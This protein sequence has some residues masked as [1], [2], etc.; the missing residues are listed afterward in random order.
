MRQ[1]SGAL[2]TAPALP[3]VG[4]LFAGS[5]PNADGHTAWQSQFAWHS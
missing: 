1:P 4:R 3:V 5:A 2:S